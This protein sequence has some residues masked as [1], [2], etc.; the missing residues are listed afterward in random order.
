MD[1]DPEFSVVL[2]GVESG[3]VGSDLVGREATILLANTLARLR[4]FVV[5]D[6]QVHVL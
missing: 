3:L 1:E 5:V 4:T 2:H 6:V